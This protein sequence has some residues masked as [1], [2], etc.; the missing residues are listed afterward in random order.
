[1]KYIYFV[2]LYLYC[3]DGFILNHPKLFQIKTHHTYTRTENVLMC[4]KKYNKPTEYKGGFAN[5]N[6]I[7]KIVFVIMLIQGSISRHNRLKDIRNITK[8]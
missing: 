4:E 6:I 1:M 3:I 5:H 7:C 2:L 8:Y